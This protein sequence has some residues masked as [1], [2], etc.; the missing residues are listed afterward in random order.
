MGKVP[1]RD[2]DRWL[3]PQHRRKVSVWQR[4][5]RPGLFVGTSSSS[6]SYP[7]LTT[8]PCLFSREGD[9]LF[10]AYFGRN[11][12]HVLKFLVGGCGR[13]HVRASSGA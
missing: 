6:V 2:G 13:V 12:R 11:T 3:V 9:S 8:Y 10:M 1:C 4:L 5:L 7:G